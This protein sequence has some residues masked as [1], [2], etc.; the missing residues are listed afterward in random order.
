MAT[1]YFKKLLTDNYIRG[2]KA[3]T[4]LQITDEAVAGLQLRYSSITGRKIFYLWYRLRGTWKQRNLK[5]GT[6]EHIATIS[7]FRRKAMK[8]KE[9]IFDG[10]DPQTELRVRAKDAIVK[11]SRRKKVKD[12]TPL[13]LEKH[14]K[15]NN[16]PRTYTSHECLIRIHVN[17]IIGDRHIDEVDLPFLQD[18]YDKLRDTKTIQIADHTFRVIST[19][20]N[21]CEKYNY[22][23]MNSNPCHLVQ[24]AKAKKMKH[25]VLSTGDYQKL[26]TAFD[27]AIIKQIYA[28]Q[29]VLALKALALTGCRAGEITNLEHDEIDLKNGYLHLKKRKTNSFN[30]PLGDA[31][32]I[33]LRD[34]LAIC[35][36]DKWVFHSP[37]DKDKPLVDLRRAFWWSLERAGLP[38]MRIHDLRHSFASMA[39]NIGEDIRM[40]KDVLG[41]TKITTTE[42]YAHTDNQKLRQTATNTAAAILR[43]I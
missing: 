21:W 16:R 24:K 25:T 8:Y 4:D 7:D 20:L 30:V 19:F 26:F 36:S 31:A 37:Q 11:E 38:K 28:P 14:C 43:K 27:E 40:L 42:I 35:K 13:F 23:A 32:I 1:L 33:V 15:C 34:A 3:A 22:R 6:Y 18:Y 5:L 2:L 12:L 10:K 39:T 9:E 17:P 29:A 41:H